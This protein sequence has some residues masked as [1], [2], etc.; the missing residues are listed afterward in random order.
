MRSANYKSGGSR[1]LKLWHRW[2][3][4]ASATQLMPSDRRFMAATAGETHEFAELEQNLGI[5]RKKLW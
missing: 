3:K 2:E 1:K 4:A 5:G